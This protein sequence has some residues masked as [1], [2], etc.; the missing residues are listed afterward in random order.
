MTPYLSISTVQMENV[1]F[2]KQFWDVLLTP[3]AVS[4][5][6]K[7]SICATRTSDKVAR[8]P[9]YLCEGFKSWEFLN[10]IVHFKAYEV[11]L[12]LIN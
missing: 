6:E 4:I 8:N 1:K 9:L 5:R 3:T 10:V 2:N 11:L 7:N 12:R